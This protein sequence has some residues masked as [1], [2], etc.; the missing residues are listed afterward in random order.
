MSNPTGKGGFIPGEASN[1]SGKKP[2][3]R[4][5]RT[6]DI[7]QQ[8]IDAGYRDP[9]ITLSE[10]Q[11]GNPDA[12]IRAQTASM[13]A[14]YLH[15][16]VVPAPIPRF[17]EV[18][19]DLPPLD[20][21]RN[22]VERIARI[23]DLVTQNLLDIALG[24]DLIAMAREYIAGLNQLEVQQLTERLALVEANQA[25]Q[26][27]VQHV[28]G[29]LPPLPGTSIIMGPMHPASPVIVDHVDEPAPDWEAKAGPEPCGKNRILGQAGSRRDSSRQCWSRTDPHSVT[30]R[31]D[32]CA[33]TGVG[34]QCIRGMAP[35][36]HSGSAS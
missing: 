36:A 18:P 33:Y 11:H 32:Q 35:A 25:N 2:G 1:P 12:S 7:V 4:N 28:Q 6:R 23:N 21:L 26:P 24:Q 16:K 19:L 8:I 30:G 31:D 3:T 13:L 17:V 22:A 34:R 9:L 10:I 5:R 27:Q 29:G 14:P 20:S 15:G